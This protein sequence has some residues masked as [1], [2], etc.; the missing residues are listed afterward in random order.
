MIPLNHSSC[1]EGRKLWFAV[2]HLASLVLA[3]WVTCVSLGAVADVNTYLGLPIVDV[4]LDFG[5]AVPAPGSEELIVTSVGTPLSMTDVRESIWHLFSLGYYSDIRVDANLRDG[6]VV[7][8]YKLTPIKIVDRFAF[9]GNLGLSRGDLREAIDERYGE[10]PQLGQVDEIAG[11]LRELYRNQGYLNTS[12]VSSPVDRGGGL[13]TLTIEIAA[14]EQ[15]RLATLVLVGQV[16][17][18]EADIFRRLDLRI[19]GHLDREALEQHLVDYVN[20]LKQDGYFEAVADH[21]VEARPGGLLLELTLTLDAG[22]RVMVEFKGD[23]LPA[24]IQDALVTIDRESSVDEDLLEDSNRRLLDYLQQRGFRRAITDYTRTGDDQ[25]LKIVY[26]VDRGPVVRV[27]GIEIEGHQLFPR[28]VFQDRLGV[29][30]GDP[31]VEAT[32]DERVTAILAAYREAG[33]PNANI[34]TDVV[35]ESGPL[36]PIVHLRLTVAEGLR[37][38]IGSIEI[39]GAPNSVVPELQAAIAARPGA[40]YE[41]AVALADRDAI[42]QRLLSLGYET[43]SVRVDA[44]FDPSTRQ[45]HLTH[46]VEAGP[47]I[48]VDHVLITG[49]FQVSTATIRREITL[50]P[51]QPLSQDRLTESRRR[52]GALGLFRR[53]RITEI[54]HSSDTR[55]DVLVVVEEVPAT[56]LGY[57]GGFE[58]GTRL[59]RGRGESGAAVEQVEF[60]PRGFF[61]I[62]RRNLWGKNRSVNLFTRVSLRPDNDQMVNDNSSNFGF[63]EY[64]V[65]ATFREPRVFNSTGEL[66][67]SAFIEQSIRSS[68]NLKQR[69]VSVEWRRPLGSTTIFTGGYTFNRDQLFD[70]RFNTEEEHL[71][72]RLFPGIA[73]STFSGAFIRDSRDDPFDPTRGELLSADTGLA[74][75]AIGSEVG[76]AK[77]LM[78]GFFY[79]RL[80]GTSSVVFASGLRVGLATG[81][82]R[83]VKVIDNNGNPVLAADGQS[84]ETVIRDLPASERFFAG[85]STTVRG[86]ALD[87]LGDDS[88]I[89][90]DGFPQGGNSLIIVNNELRFPIWESLGAVAFLDV[91]NVFKTV[92]RMTFGGLRGGAGF[93]LRYRSPIGPIRVDLGFKLDQ[94]DFGSGVRESLTALHVSIGQAF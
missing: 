10:R 15:A 23:S 94:R 6:G 53:I 2:R 30:V 78:Q 33:Y 3:G 84:V 58:A 14:G 25:E 50:V 87:R 42:L 51:G 4:K 22:P 79:R 19:G 88:T 18:E 27:G 67:F 43:A 49:Q 76:F 28:A 82:S 32:F 59:R 63:N 38:V 62:G 57:G 40:V 75:R 36:G 66:L 52:L 61:E 65:L 44:S 80:P 26:H 13:T 93:G 5:G 45:A 89:D 83:T 77:T 9:R 20:N 17:E 35:E 12:I 54:S 85:G 21:T 8:L 46:V 60:A 69:G 37:M 90:Q 34:T 56:T 24:E 74:G 64:R 48:L 39:E 91:G 86:F 41:R 31:F 92:E 81:F 47:Q 11:F 73:L 72:D 16:L 68:F 7:L 1:A 29:V 70:E 71:I 55:R